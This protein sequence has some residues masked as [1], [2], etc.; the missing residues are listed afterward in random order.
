[1][2]D[3]SPLPCE[4]GERVRE[5]NSLVFRGCRAVH[6]GLLETGPASLDV[7]SPAEWANHQLQ[8]APTPREAGM[9]HGSFVW[10]G[11]LIEVVADP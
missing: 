9:I 4:R 10:L 3:G 2:W 1:M 11:V 6:C 5:A 8:L 7:D